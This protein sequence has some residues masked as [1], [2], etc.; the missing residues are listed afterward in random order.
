MHP[1]VMC[2]MRTHGCMGWR[3]PP[4]AHR[5]EACKRAGEL[6]EH[7]RTC[8]CPCAVLN[9][10]F[11]WGHCR[12]SGAAR[13]QGARVKRFMRGAAGGL[14]GGVFVP[15]RRHHELLGHPGARAPRGGRLVRV[16]RRSPNAHRRSVGRVCGGP[17]PFEALPWWLVASMQCLHSSSRSAHGM[18]EHPG[19]EQRAV[20]LQRG[21]GAVAL[22]RSCSSAPAPLSAGPAV[23]GGLRMA[24]HPR[25]G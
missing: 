6:L 11:W 12:C 20:Q 25:R 18:R 3:Q 24:H 16:L 17:D 7:A 5:S 15:S 19:A 10:Q 22:Q 14:H 2:E 21:A 8:E 1:S 13:E 23:T 4:A 9:A